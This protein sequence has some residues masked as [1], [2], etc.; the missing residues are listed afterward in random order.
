MVH[1]LKMAYD[2][3]LYCIFSVVLFVLFSLPGPRRLTF[4]D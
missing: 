2:D 4:V 1:P 3:T